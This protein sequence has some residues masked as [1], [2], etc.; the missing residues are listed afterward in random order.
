M[1]RSELEVELEPEAEE[2]EKNSG[3][4]CR[5]PWHAIKTIMIKK[6]KIIN[7]TSTCVRFMIVEFYIP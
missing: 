4:S 6:R 5:D 2:E 3:R 7:K 1:V